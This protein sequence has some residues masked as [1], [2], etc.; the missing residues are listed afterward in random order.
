MTKR[1]SRY[2]LEAIGNDD[3]VPMQDW[4]H[5][6]IHGALKPLDAMAA[7]M[8]IQWGKGRLEELVSP[9]TAAKFEA[10]RAKLDVAISDNDVAL[11]IRRAKNMLAGWQALD[12]EARAAGHKPAP[13]ELW[14]ATAPAEDGKDEARIVIAKDNS[15]ATLAQTDLPVYTVTEI[16]R[17]VRAWRSQMDVHVAKTVF[18]GAEVVRIDGD[19]Q[20]DDELPF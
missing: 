18:P 2:D 15:A 5:D 6:Q 19:E 4:Q 14:H 7:E 12:K 9:E 10:A 17:I 13:P 11:V 1:K 3:Y 20:F 16:A 8:E